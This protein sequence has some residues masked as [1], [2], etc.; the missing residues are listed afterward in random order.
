MTPVLA[1]FT[2]LVG[3]R[4]AKPAAIGSAILLLIALLS[5]GKCVYDRHVVATYVDKVQVKASHATDKA[6]DQRA[7]DTIR[8]DQNE[9]ELHDAINAAPG[10]TP[11]PAAHALSCKRLHKIGRYPASCGPAGPDGKEADSQ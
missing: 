7:K 10:G 4:F 6:A 8:N 9:K 2:R 11:S 3:Q 5:I 1:L